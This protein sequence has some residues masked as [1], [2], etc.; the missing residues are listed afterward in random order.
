MD[1]LDFNDSYE[2]INIFRNNKFLKEFAIKENDIK[3]IRKAKLDL[4][5]IMDISSSMKHCLEALRAM[6]TNLKCVFDSIGIKNILF[7]FYSDYDLGSPDG[8]N[9]R[10][11]C[12][13]YD[14]LDKTITELNNLSIGKLGTG[15]SS[16]EALIT[17]LYYLLAITHKKQ[18]II[19]LT[20]DG[21]HSDY[22]KIN[23][24]Y[25]SLNRDRQLEVQFLQKHNLLVN[26]SDV[27][28]LLETRGDRS[29]L[30]TNATRH[31]FTKYFSTGKNF[32]IKYNSC[33]DTYIFTLLFLN[34]LQIFIGNEPNFPEF[35]NISFINPGKVPE[36]FK[37]LI[38]IIKLT[39][40][41]INSVQSISCYNFIKEMLQKNNLYYNYLPDF[42]CVK[43]FEII[44]LLKKEDELN[45]NLSLKF[46]KND[47]DQNKFKIIDATIKLKLKK[48][49]KLIPE[50]SEYF[51]N[52]VYDTKKIYS[53]NDFLKLSN[54]ISDILKTDSWI[55]YD[56]TPITNHV[57]FQ[58]LSNEILS[59]ETLKLFREKIMG[60][61]IV[62]FKELFFSG[63][64]G[65]PVSLVNND[66]NLLDLVFSVMTNFQILP[67][68][69]ILSILNLLNDKSSEINTIE[70]KLPKEL[71]QIIK[72]Y[73]LMNY[74]IELQWILNSDMSNEI[75]NWYSNQFGLSLLRNTILKIQK[76]TSEIKYSSVIEKVNFLILFDEIKQYSNTTITFDLKIQDTISKS[77]FYVRECSSGYIVPDCLFLENNDCVCCNYIF[78]DRDDDNNVTINNVGKKYHDVATNTP[79]KYFVFDGIC[80][81]SEY[82]MSCLNCGNKYAVNSINKSVIPNVFF[83]DLVW[84]KEMVQNVINY[85]VLNVE[86]NMFMLD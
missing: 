19:I 21:P 18:N 3:R 4:V 72:E 2:N 15:D 86:R 14:N 6:I 51:S 81:Q 10:V 8:K 66:L 47:F 24:N 80:N 27:V 59:Q 84:H 83:V 9:L 50:L 62:T 78:T 75:P 57:Y 23:N 69:F 67:P 41:K 49:F 70:M 46:L 1:K 48:Y 77:T 40:N 76:W 58:N 17:A 37:I 54:K 52:I 61:K 22:S 74:K 64:I 55:I 73:I 31:M 16:P 25:E 71:S 43:L 38:P 13:F 56:K 39:K 26:F 53:F 12:S 82:V 5:I 28:K 45:N 63:S 79:S 7:I 30:I 68:T 29:I 32:I 85:L 35:L 65:F 42:F 34:A 60:Y 44:N 20:D 33:Y 36:K 11:V